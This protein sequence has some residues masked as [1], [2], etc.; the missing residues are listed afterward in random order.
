MMIS[1]WTI[2]ILIIPTIAL[3]FFF[4]DYRKKRL[5]SNIYKDADKFSRLE[6]LKYFLVAFTLAV[7]G[8]FLVPLPQFLFMLLFLLIFLGMLYITIKRLHDINMNGWWAIVNISPLSNLIMVLIC[9]FTPSSKNT[10]DF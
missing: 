3:V 6:Y 5:S 1:V 7:L 9:F 10:N 2:I 8:E 4:I